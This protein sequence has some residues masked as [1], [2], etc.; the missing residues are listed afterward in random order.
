MSNSQRISRR[1][2]SRSRPPLTRRSR[3][4]RTTRKSSRTPRATWT[5]LWRTCGKCLAS[6]CSTTLLLKRKKAAPIPG[7]D[8]STPA[9]NTGCQVWLW[10]ESLEQ[11]LRLGGHDTC[12]C[13]Y[14]SHI[15]TFSSWRDSA[16]ARGEA[17]GGG[18][19]WAIIRAHATRREQLPRLARPNTR[20]AAN[21]RS[22]LTTTP[23]YFS[24][25]DG[26]S[27]RGKGGACQVL[28]CHAWPTRKGE[29]ES[30]FLLVTTF[31][32]YIL[33]KSGAHDE[34]TESSSTT[35]TSSSAPGQ[36]A[37]ERRVTERGRQAR[38]G[39]QEGGHHQPRRDRLHRGVSGLA[40]GALYLH[41]PDASSNW[42][43]TACRR[44][45]NDM[46]ESIELARKRSHYAALP[47]LS[48]LKDA[49]N[50]KDRHK[51]VPRAIKS[52]WNRKMS[53]STTTRWCTG[54]TSAS[55]VKLFDPKGGHA[56][57][58]VQER[59]GQV[60]RQHNRFELDRVAQ[61]LLCTQVC[62]L[63]WHYT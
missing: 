2:R 41:K 34:L 11:R 10:V 42:I 38:Q 20:R 15:I 51:E 28:S 9:G 18:L 35:T 48:V 61:G 29:V 14:C 53:R 45:T 47:Q 33:S 57:V 43:T 8:T 46:L 3:A 40:S 5:P 23:S 60:Y 17:E 44:L 6:R 32:V 55:A 27:R 31:S 52:T 58:P 25:F 50:A 49:H 54:R 16:A 26:V 1:R 22:R 63:L 13:C 12:C 7:G 39:V 21:K 62:T 56:H 37:L 19:A 4:S 59:V 30:L 24:W 36:H